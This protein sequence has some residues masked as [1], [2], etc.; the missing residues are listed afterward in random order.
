M[1]TSTVK[2]NGTTKLADYQAAENWS[3]YASYMQGE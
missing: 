3:A 2:L 1:A